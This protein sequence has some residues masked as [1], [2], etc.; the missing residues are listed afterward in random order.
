MQVRW[1]V[2]AAP[3]TS[4]IK[5]DFKKAV[6]CFAIGFDHAESPRRRHY[7]FW[8]LI[9]FVISFDPAVAVGSGLG[10]GKHEN[11]LQYV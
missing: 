3:D 10:R 7:L 9:A 5:H 4:L 8:S 11:S 1:S 6:I 2:G